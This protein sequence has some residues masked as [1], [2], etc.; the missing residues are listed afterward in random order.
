MLV[1]EAT[2]EVLHYLFWKEQK[3]YFPEEKYHLFTSFTKVILDAY[4]DKI[5]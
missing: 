1:V 4:Y 2:T 3:N 5:A